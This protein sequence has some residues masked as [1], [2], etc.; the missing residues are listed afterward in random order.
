MVR[1]S[2]AGERLKFDYS[3]TL[4]LQDWD[5]PPLITKKAVLL[6][7]LSELSL[8]LPVVGLSNVLN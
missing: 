8:R 3:S 2:K 7:R 1:K 4:F 5:S 6:S